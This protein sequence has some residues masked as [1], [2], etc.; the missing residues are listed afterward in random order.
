MGKAGMQS[1]ALLHAWENVSPCNVCIPQSFL[2]PPPSESPCFQ[3]S[4]S[5]VYI[6]VYPA[7][8]QLPL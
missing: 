8:L 4:E 5:L 7:A 1:C 3:M 6:E 2:L